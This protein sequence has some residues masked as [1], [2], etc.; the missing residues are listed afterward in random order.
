MIKVCKLIRLIESLPTKMKVH[1]LRKEQHLPISLEQ[2]W[3]F[4]ST[5]KNLNEI[6][7]PDLGFRMEYSSSE[8]MI[9][10]QIITYRIRIAPLIHVPWVT[11]I[12]S[13]KER[14]SFIDVQLHGPYKLWHHL[15]HFTK[16]ENGVLM[17]DVVHYALPF[18]FLGTMVHSLFV[19]KKLEHI[20]SFRRKMLSDFFQSS[21]LAETESRHSTHDSFH[22]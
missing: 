18:S 22:L 12:R 3:G 1:V 9:E 11:E 13:V 2:A 19:R 14:E 21:S 5:P 20:F 7:P 15:H 8:K 4:F 6:T 17:V 10:G 16:T